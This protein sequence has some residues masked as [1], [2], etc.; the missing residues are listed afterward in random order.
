MVNYTSYFVSA[1]INSNLKIMP[2]IHVRLIFFLKQVG[3]SIH[4]AKNNCFC[5]DLR[6]KIC[7]FTDSY[8]FLSPVNDKAEVCFFFIVNIILQIVKKQHI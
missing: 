4:S 1:L 6:G 2:G 5:F 3:S 8:S 7:S